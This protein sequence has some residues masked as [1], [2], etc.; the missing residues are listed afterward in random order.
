ML[1]AIFVK[2]VYGLYLICSDLVFI[3]LFPHLVL[4][5]HAPNRTNKYGMVV[6]FTIALILRVLSGEPVL[7]YNAVIK[8]YG[9]FEP[10]E[11]DYGN[12][13][14]GR[15]RFPF[16]NLIMALNFIITLFTTYVTQQLFKRY[17]NLLKYDFLDAEGASG[18]VEPI[19]PTTPPERKK[20]Q[21]A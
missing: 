19:T 7:K 16:R 12:P 5:V 17:P 9:Y 20:S 3:L 8:Y 21:E 15:Q 18:S 4:V 10:H 2:T 1:I 14:Y 13:V 6:G 11:D